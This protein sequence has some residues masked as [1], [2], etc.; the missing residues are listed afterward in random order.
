MTLHARVPAGA[1]ISYAI[2]EEDWFPKVPGVDRLR[3]RTA[4][5]KAGVQP[6]TIAALQF[7][8]AAAFPTGAAADEPG[9]RLASIGN[10]NLKP[11]VTTEYEGGFD[12]GFF[13][14]RISVEATMFKKLSEDA[15]FNR[16]L[17]PSY[18]TAIGSASPT[19]WENLAAVENKG[20]ELTVDMQVIRLRAL[21]WDVR[22]NGSLLKNKLV[23][24]G[25]VPLPT[26]PGARNEVG[27]PLFGLWDRQITGYSDKNGDGLIGD[28]EIDVSAALAF[29][30]SSLPQREAGMGT[31]IGLLNRALQFSVLFDYR[32]DFYK[33]WQYEE[34][35]CQ[36][37]GNCKAVNDPSSPLAD[38]AAATAANSSS[39]RTI[40]GYYV[41]ND[42]VKLREVSANYTLPETFA[43]KYLRSRSASLSLSA[44][45][46]GYP[47]SKYPGIDPESNNSVANTG[48]GN[49]E[50][51]AQPPMRY[52]ITRLNIQF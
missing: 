30:G 25:G 35:R 48:G 42:F 32:G 37:T 28:D 36:S 41:P 31:T 26:A 4:Y 40:W 46:L 44:R 23:D 34:W 6:S 20:T 51:T 47:W 14:D 13:N 7:L 10:Q 8:G 5:G 3:L 15:L 52:F 9:L 21:T 39:K 33:R 43:R 50:L 38:Q 19:R 17:P 49:S 1:A 29:R 22:L 16:P 18:G 27:Y 11:E 24:A 45:N 12:V 2:S